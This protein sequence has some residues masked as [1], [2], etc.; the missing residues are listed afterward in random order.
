MESV[1]SRMSEDWAADPF[2]ELLG[3]KSTGPGMVVP[4]GSDGTPLGAAVAVFGASGPRLLASSSAM[5]RRMEE[6]ISSIDGS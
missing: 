3:T 5:M 6:R 4:G 1:N 2:R